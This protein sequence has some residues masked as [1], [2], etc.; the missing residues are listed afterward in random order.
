[1]R[2]LNGI[3][4]GTFPL[5]GPFTPVDREMA[6]KIVKIYL[7]LGGQ[8]LDTA[9]TY[10]FGNVETLLGE[11]LKDFPRARYFVSTGCGHVLS[12]DGQFKL[13]SGY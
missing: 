6:S 8:Y 9:P 5:A 2:L 4:L 12:A 13:R 10:A 1:M 11:I 3:G 7:D